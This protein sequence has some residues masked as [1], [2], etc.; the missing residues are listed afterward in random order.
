MKSISHLPQR[1]RLHFSPS[2]MLT[3][4]SA[5]LLASC[6]P[7]SAQQGTVSGIAAETV[8]TRS[9]PL[10][11]I[12][13]SPGANRVLQEAPTQV[14]VTQTV[15]PAVPISAQVTRLN[16]DCGHVI[17]LLITNRFRQNA[18]QNGSELSPGLR[19]GIPETEVLG[20]LELLSIQLD[21]TVDPRNG[22]VFDIALRN[23]SRVILENVTV[24]AVAVVGQINV[25]SPTAVCS[26]SRIDEGEL[27]SLRIQLPAASMVLGSAGTPAVPF[28]TLVVAIDSFDEFVESNELN[29]VR[30][31]RRTDIPI[32]PVAVLT[33]AASV[34]A[35]Q[36]SEPTQSSTS[37]VIA[38]PDESRPASPLDAID[39]DKLG[40]ETIQP[41]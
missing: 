4:L 15:V 38:V 8:V 16:V 2:L 41:Q 36:I 25:H 26:V 19:L 28:D 13:T 20:D 5:M 12:Q 21:S 23:N 7:A 3:G 24:S 31:I 29:N 22:P 10:G 40:D 27:T 34:A 14:G 39:P 18:F 6:V 1:H 37:P 32:L 35:P 9:N 17:E 33:P 11:D 30:I